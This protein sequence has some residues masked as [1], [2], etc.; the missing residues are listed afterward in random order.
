[1]TITTF[2]ITCAVLLIISII[3]FVFL[4]K[5]DHL[6]FKFSAKIKDI[7]FI[8]LIPS[9]AFAIALIIYRI[10]PTCPKIPFLE[11]CVEPFDMTAIIIGVIGILVAVITVI[12]VEQKNDEKNKK[13]ESNINSLTTCTDTIL[14]SIS[15][16]KPIKS[17]K[18]RINA[19]KDVISHATK[20]KGNQL[21][22]LFY[23]A[24]YGEFLI[25]N[26]RA[27]IDPDCQHTDNRG[28]NSVLNKSSHDF[29]KNHVEDLDNLKQ[30]IHKAFNEYLKHSQ[31]GKIEFAVLRNS[32]LD[33]DN[34][35]KLMQFS[36]ERMM[37]EKT[38]VILNKQGEESIKSLQ[39]LPNNNNYENTF[40]H[41][42]NDDEVSMYKNMSNEEKEN[43]FIKFVIKQNTEFENDFKPFE[44]AGRV[45]FISLDY[46]PFQF[47]LSIPE[48]S[49]DKGPSSALLIF[50]NYYSIGTHD[51]IIS[52]HTQNPLLCNSLHNMFTTL[53]SN[54]TNR[55]KYT[56]SF[57][58]LF[59]GAK[60]LYIMLKK[61]SLDE[62]EIV[63]N[64]I[65][66]KDVTPVPDI[67]AKDYWISVFK[68]YDIRH[69][70]KAL[71]IES[72]TATE[73]EIKTSLDAAKLSDKDDYSL[74]AVGLFLNPVASLIGGKI[75][76]DGNKL[77]ELI[78]REENLNKNDR[79]CIKVAIGGK[80]ENPLFLENVLEANLDTDNPATYDLAIFAKV[81]TADGKWMFVCG[82]IHFLGTE[83]IADCVR[84]NSE[85]IYHFVQD[86]QFIA[87][88]RIPADK[89]KPTKLLSISMINASDDIRYKDNFTAPVW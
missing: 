7:L 8:L 73:A 48:G 80:K 12:Y 78:P 40:I 11:E 31:N 14:N 15:A 68:E 33:P 89:N 58:H 32:H 55:E 61:A 25:H 34:P 53:Q 83:K 44:R 35:S 82:G 41:W 54:Q 76:K 42:V 50:T 52:F 43:S 86:N 39:G 79:N 23:S 74:M 18:E 24:S 69:S 28:D 21:N 27:L 19:I 2:I 38:T 66:F 60:R 30:G 47:I 49:K 88:F 56:H 87:V 62:S 77:F 67:E 9:F 71:Y 65:G 3:S 16:I 59:K 70:G 13:L 4:R 84:D 26:L 75:A 85:T 10:F 17:H 36:K 72:K 46:L 81:K 51:S 20:T 45:K 64:K 22:V 5:K 6:F 63:K 29:Y 37:K 1:M 57:K